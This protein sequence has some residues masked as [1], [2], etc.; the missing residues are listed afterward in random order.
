V[1]RIAKAERE[2]EPWALITETMR[3]EHRYRLDAPAGRTVKILDRVGSYPSA[4]GNVPVA[5]ASL[6]RTGEIHYSTENAGIYLIPR[7]D[8]PNGPH[9]LGEIADQDS[10]EWWVSTPH[11]R[12]CNRLA[13]RGRIP[14]RRILDSW[15]NRAVTNLF[16]Q[17]SADVSDLRLRARD[18]ADAYGEVKRKSS[19]AI[20]GLWPKGARSP[21]WR[22]D[23]SISV[24]AEAA[25]RHWVRA[26]EAIAAGADLVRLGNVDEVAFLIPPKA[27]RTWLPDPYREG[28]SF[29][30][31]S[32][33]GTALAAEWN[34][35]GR[36][37]G[38]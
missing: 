34:R 19:I 7:F 9:P 11:L 5:A 1:L 20:R 2:I 15:T 8:W 4:M 10:E 30:C 14:P 27:R 31:V 13:T 33:K 36:H 16:K 3:G 32:V 29:G 18:D 6:Q 24:R 28:T 37:A 23:W 12:L 26:D 22:P 25:V 38:R 21:F 35:K 17:F